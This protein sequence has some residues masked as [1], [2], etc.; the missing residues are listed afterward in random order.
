MG[1]LDDLDLSATLER[2]EYEERLYKAQ[3]KLL[4]LRLE[5]AGLMEDSELGPGV[6]VVF[7][8]SDAGGKGGAIRRS[9]ERR[10]I[11]G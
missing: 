11:S 4:A 2:E 6:T 5:L 8:G 9:V 3:R 10:R 1:R 7:E